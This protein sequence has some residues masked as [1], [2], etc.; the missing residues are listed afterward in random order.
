MLNSDN[1]HQTLFEANCFENAG[2]FEMAEKIYLEAIRLLAQ[3]DGQRRGVVY[4]NLGLCAE[5]H[6]LANAV[7][8]YVKAIEDLVKHKGDALLQCAHAHY[9]IARVYLSQSDTRA[10]D[11]IEQAVERYERCPFASAA[12]VA[13]ARILRVLASI[14][15]RKAVT[16]KE[17]NDTWKSVSGLPIAAMS[18]S[19]LV[20]FLHVVALVKHRKS[21]VEFEAFLRNVSDYAGHEVVED[22]RLTIKNDIAIKKS[23]GETT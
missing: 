6:D 10:L 20:S 12:D 16:E 14:H 8:Y 11:F 9:N 17:I 3:D 23:R 1:V 5:K 7:T 22:I 2:A 15:V 18:K 4:I 13:D 19:Y 21:A